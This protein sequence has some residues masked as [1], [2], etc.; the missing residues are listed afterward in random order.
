MHGMSRYTMIFVVLLLQQVA[1]VSQRRLGKMQHVDGM[2]KASFKVYFLGESEK[3]PKA[4]EGECGFGSYAKAFHGPI[5][6]T[7][8]PGSTFHIES[9]TLPPSLR[10][11][12][13]SAIRSSPRAS[14]LRSRIGGD[15][16][17]CPRLYWYS[18]WF[19][20][21]EIYFS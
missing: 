20:A 1:A 13:G 8:V 17:A 12:S 2:S 7:A 19:G 9:S 4:V 6:A 18:T 16:P 3:T 5:T 11:Y 21:Y 14:S 10:P 15:G